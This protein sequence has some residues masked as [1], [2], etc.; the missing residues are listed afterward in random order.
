MWRTRA[1][2]GVGGSRSVAS[3]APDGSD[4]G[5]QLCWQTEIIVNKCRR[6][7][8]DKQGSL[9]GRVLRW[10]RRVPKVRVL[11]F[12]F[13]D[14]LNLTATC[15]EWSVEFATTVRCSAALQHWVLE[16][17]QARPRTG[18]AHFQQIAGRRGRGTLTGE[19]QCSRL[20]HMGHQTIAGSNHS[21]GPQTPIDLCVCF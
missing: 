2:W 10:V 1:L 13:V 12:F 3:E 17:Q 9:A 16:L 8:S 14:V 19:Q 5:G 4:G 15:S 11:A 18:K 21:R 20:D 6:R 7:C